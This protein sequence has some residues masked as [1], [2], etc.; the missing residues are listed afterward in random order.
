MVLPSQLIEMEVRPQDTESK[1]GLLQEKEEE[2]EEVW[3][4]DGRHFKRWNSSL[5]RCK[6]GGKTHATKTDKDTSL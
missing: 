5:D 4:R 1:V 2:E 3:T 6:T